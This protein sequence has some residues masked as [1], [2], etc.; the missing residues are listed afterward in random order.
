M[1]MSVAVAVMAAVLSLAGCKEEKASCTAEE[2]QK[3]AAEMTT[4]LQALA[5]TNPEKLAAVAT[6]AQEL[7]GDLANAGTD[8][9]KACAAVDEL[10]KAME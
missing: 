5:T 3:K 4:K 10:I 9:A 6:K 7:Q 1:R 8:P 2:A